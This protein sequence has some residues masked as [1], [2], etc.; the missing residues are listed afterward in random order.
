MT[1]T[2]SRSATSSTASRSQ[3]SSLLHAL[4]PCLPPTSSGAST[5]ASDCWRGASAR[6]R[7]A[8]DAARD[9]RVVVRPAHR[10]GAALFDRLA[11]FRGTFSLDAAEAVCAG[12][13]VDELDVVD[14]LDRLV[15]KSMVLPIESRHGSRFRLLETLR[16]FA[17]SKLAARGESDEYRGRHVEHFLAFALSE[18]PRT[19]SADQRDVLA[20][21]MTE[22]PNVNAML[23]RLV[24]DGRWAEAATVARLRSGASGRP[25]LPRMAGAGACRSRPTPTSSSSTNGS[26]SSPSPRTS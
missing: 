24:D 20:R 14:L 9:R 19:R 22:R 7:T 11:V 6:A 5:S 16:E 15:D 13:V 23:D 3:S 25:L 18:G 2:C 26:S 10:G 17:E 21:L 4:V 12:G 1:P 8:P